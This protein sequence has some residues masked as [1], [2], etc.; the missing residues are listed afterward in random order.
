[1]QIN[2]WHRTKKNVKE[3]VHHTKSELLA[4]CAQIPRNESWSPSKSEHLASET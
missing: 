2:E 1:M 3:F 4:P